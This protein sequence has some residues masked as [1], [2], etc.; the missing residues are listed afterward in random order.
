[1]VEQKVLSLD[2]PVGCLLGKMLGILLGWDE[3]ILDRTLFELKYVGS[4]VGSEV[5]ANEG[6]TVGSDI[7]IKNVGSSVGAVVARK[8]GDCVDEFI[9]GRKVGSSLV[10]LKRTFH[11]SS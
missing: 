3:G 8:K 2:T 6:T 10:Y 4:S 1:L 7:A 5:I 9:L 11:F